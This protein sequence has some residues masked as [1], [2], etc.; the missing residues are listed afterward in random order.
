VN[1]AASCSGR[2]DR[3][4]VLVLLHGFTGSGRSMSGIARHFERDYDVLMPD[5][6]G[7]GSS[8]AIDYGFDACVDQLLAQLRAAGHSR[9]HWLGYSMG[10]RVALGCAVREPDGVASLILLAGRAGIAD[11]VE[12]ETRRCAD[13]V[14]AARIERDGVEA[15]VD[16]WMALPLFA[17]QQRLGPELL[18]QARRERLANSARGLAAS[19]RGMGPGAQPPLFDALP[20]VT[21]PTLL[22]AGA[23]DLP[24]V[25]AAQSLASAL[26]HSE[27]RV[28]A[29]AGH[30]LHLEQPA[31]CMQAIHEFLR[32]ATRPAPSRYPPSL[33]ENLT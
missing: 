12:R 15:F 8:V 14:L 23:L 24:F 10:A 29:A 7:H 25:A 3:R 6:P 17:T 30:A 4:E 18:A 31:A 33:Q 9:A 22:L 20:R 1:G 13:D 16:A 19:L 21:A 26:P 32:R 27:L 28:I 5:L 11:P 2:R